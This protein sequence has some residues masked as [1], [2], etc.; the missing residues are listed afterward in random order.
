MACGL[1]PIEITLPEFV[2]V[3]SEVVEVLPIEQPGIMAIVE[4]DL[5]RISPDRSNVFNID[6]LFVQLKLRTASAMSSH[7]GGRRIHTK[8]FAGIIEY[9]A[10]VETDLQ[11]MLF[12]VQNDILR[13]GASSH[14]LILSRLGRRENKQ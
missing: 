9:L 5:D 11:A 3:F 8:K 12:F 13:L 1:Q 7:L 4:N 10:V 14:A 6:V 2:T